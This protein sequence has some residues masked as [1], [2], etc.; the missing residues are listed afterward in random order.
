MN[1]LLW[2]ANDSSSSSGSS[3]KNNNNNVLFYVMF[4]QIGAHSPSQT[5]RQNT[6]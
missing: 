6:V 1:E 4:L 2:K 3:S 5:D